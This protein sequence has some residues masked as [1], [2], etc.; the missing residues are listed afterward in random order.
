M[1]SFLYLIEGGLTSGAC[2]CA[3]EL[4]NRLK[5]T[6]FR[7]IIITQH[8]NDFNDYCDTNGIE[9]YHLHYAR[10][11]SLS[12]NRTGWL[13]AFFMRP[14][15]NFIAFKRL[16]KKIDLKKICFVHSNGGSIDF[17]AYLYK[18]KGI[19]HFWHVRD[20]FLF[21]NTLPPLI[22]NLAL[23][24]EQNATSIITVSNAL[25]NVLIEAG[26]SPN[27]VQTIYDGI[28]NNLE[29]KK[30]L[31]FERR[32]KLH[33]ACV[34]QICKLKG[35]E[36]LVEAINLMTSTERSYFHFDFFGEIIPE[37]KDIFLSKIK[38]YDIEKDIQLKG[39]S[40]YIL[41]NLDDYDIGVQPSHSEGFSRVTAEY[42]AAGLCVIA[43]AEG[44]IPELIQHNHNGLLYEDYNAAEL[45]EL[46]IYCYHN[47]TKMHA[48][49]EKAQK[50][51][52]NKYDIRINFDKIINLYNRHSKVRY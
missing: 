43:A 4:I 17:G 19:T 7:P 6:N 47:Q 37:F 13:I 18:K 2:M 22:R 24:M 34:G 3:I 33:V 1:K 50:D 40:N 15:L 38:K 44:A 5:D 46:L 20:F 39:F 36:T 25:R 21:N 48:L 52:F 14:I 30:E 9:N 27:K 11:C 10:I 32:K 23:Y 42:M 16:S 31:K 41:Q 28:E 12:Q 51:F 45:K 49:A 8:K 35:Q 29:P 26:C